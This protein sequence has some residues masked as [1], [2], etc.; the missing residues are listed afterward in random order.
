MDE[1]VASNKAVTRPGAGSGAAQ[2][3]PRPPIPSSHGDGVT[4]H[5]PLKLNEYYGL[6]R[7]IYFFAKIDEFFTGHRQTSTGTATNCEPFPTLPNPT[8]PSANVQSSTEPLSTDQHAY[9]LRLFWEA[10]HPLLHIPGLS[11][12][13]AL[14]DSLWQEK[15]EKRETHDALINCM[16]ALGMQYG[17]G[18][19]LASRILELRVAGRRVTSDDSW[20]GFEYFRR[21]RDYMMLNA[22]ISLVGMQCYALM[23]LYLLNA[24]DF[25]SAY[26]MLGIAIRNAHG[27]NLHREPDEHT[28]P[29]QTDLH[30]RVWWLLFTLDVRCS[31]QI[32]KPVAV[33]ASVI[34]CALPEDDGLGAG[35]F[36]HAA[37]LAM[38]VDNIDRLTSS[39]D[40]CSE[41]S[42]IAVLEHR[43]ATLSAALPHLERWRLELPLELLSPR[44]ERQGSPSQ[45]MSTAESPLL[46][47]LGVTTSLHRQ[48]VLLEVHYHN[49]YIML[50]RPFICFPRDF[51]LGHILQPQTDQHTRSALQ[52]AIVMAIIIHGVC[53]NSDTLFGWP[54]IL[55]PL[56]NATVTIFAFILANPLCGRAP[57]ARLTIKKILNVFE[58][59]ATTDALAARAKDVVLSLS[60]RLDD[61]IA[62][63]GQEP[64]SANLGKAALTAS[65]PSLTTFT[66]RVSPEPSALTSRV[67]PNADDSL[68]SWIAT[69]DYDVWKDYQDGLDSFLGNPFDDLSFDFSQV[70]E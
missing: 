49:A 51:N 60:S 17:H 5:T 7:P 41:A 57:G 37:K 46:L 27:M 52:H 56:Y 67:S 66:S 16:T 18:A 48:R 23:A 30:R 70:P 31:L 61:I 53:S 19:D 35:Y 3:Q 13:R 26:S 4:E 1:V 43:A 54:E 45:S 38:A 20:A 28:S 62:K 42:N 29:E 39:V 69:L 68:R 12:F 47:E 40:M 64:K 63:L 55:Q 9:F 2:E 6:D 25:K 34:T 36:T 50:Q 65:V 32:R 58:A 10:Y 22:D 24:S 21:C 59:F 33:Q 14:Y 44:R 11:V 15:A 8:A